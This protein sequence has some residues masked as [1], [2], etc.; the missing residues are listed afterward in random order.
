LRPAGGD[1]SV[2]VLFMRIIVWGI[3]YSPEVTGI[4]PFNRGLCDYLHGSGH[5][6][7][8]VTTFSYYPTWRK[9][10]ADS[11][12]LYRT[13]LI[14]GVP[15]HRCWHYVPGRTT[16]AK[17]ILHE[18]SFALS[19]MWRV[20]VLPKA[21][22]Y[23]VVSPPLLLGP[24]AWLVT[25]LKR[26]RYTFHV[27]DLQPDAALGL[28]M[29][30]PGLFSKALFHIEAWA[31]HGAASVSGISAGM[32]A[33]FARK[34]VPEAKRR[35]F[36]NWVGGAGTGATPSA[37]RDFRRRHGIP[38]D[39]LLA[40]YSGNIGRK[41][42]LEM[43][44]EAARS[45]EAG[46]GSGQTVAILI[47]GDGA[48]REELAAQL[49][50]SAVRVLR[51]LPLL[52]DDDYRASLAATDVA[53]ITQAPGTGQFFFPSKLLSVL[54][55]GRPV[56]TVA[57]A[58][59]ELA[60]AVEAGGFGI[61]CLPGRPEA[62]ASTLIELAGDRARLAGLASRTSWVQQFARERVL[63]DY[64]AHL[65]EITLPVENRRR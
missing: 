39:A 41:Q 36:P 31:Y 54:A 35:Y 29:I 59:S 28:G 20:L 50:R 24:C 60:R 1:V 30:K 38:E 16:A 58:D 48:A 37:A 25:R 32:L 56:V 12:R 63:G 11:G 17:R 3:N 52:A 43:L 47:I 7:R 9:S 21:D 45:L 40:V 64:A 62:L 61:N 4:A 6:V 18:L 23:V 34:G 55:A 49:E 44:V 57:D 22:V 27:Q 10:P 26:S 15:V 2:V 13:D 5:A 65:V 42:G 46:G 51:L 19:S 33:A 14:A 53:V 8:M